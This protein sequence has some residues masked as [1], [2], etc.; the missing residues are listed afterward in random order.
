MHKPVPTKALMAA[1]LAGA[2]LFWLAGVAI[3]GD[4]AGS[5]TGRWHNAGTGEPPFSRS[6]D[7]QR[8]WDNGACW[9]QCGAVCV[10]SQAECLKS[11]AGQQS[12]IERSSACDRSCQRQCRG[13]AGP[14]LPVD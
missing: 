13:W 7:V 6:A 12:C 14:F 10:W 5:M 4:A 11:G 2:G 9:S 1:F 3:A 8:V